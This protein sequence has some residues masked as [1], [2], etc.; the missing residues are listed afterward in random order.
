MPHAFL[1]ILAAAA[2]SVVAWRLRTLDGTGALAATLVGSVVLGFGGVG[3]ALVLVLFFVSSSA[4]S[5][6]PPRGERS[7]RGARQV[8]ANGSL[9]ALAVALD[10]LH[11]LGQVAFLGAVAAAT[12]DTWATEIGT[13]LGK[14]PRSVLTF[15]PRTP[16]TSGAVSLPGL[17]GAAAGAL[18]VAVAGGL[19]V[20]GLDGTVS[21][22]VGLA[23]FVGSLVDSLA[24][25]GAQAI[26]RCPACDASPE[27][28]RHDG[29]PQKAER[30]WGVPG[31]DNDAVNWLATLTGGL[32]AVCLATLL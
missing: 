28:A 7:A 6:L 12:A 29:C 13:R 24:G 30:V 21:A 8:L 5:L 3:S 18:A 26:Y 9:A 15:R 20:P 23:G 1:T 2:V 11:P 10:S 22:A 32:V 16:G 19:L 4:L 14:N 17:A 27:V 25:A 31:L